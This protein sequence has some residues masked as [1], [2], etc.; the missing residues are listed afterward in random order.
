MRSERAVAAV[1]DD[2]ELDPRRAA[3]VEERLDRS[4]D[5]AAGVEDVVDE[6]DGSS[7]EREVELR[8]AHDGLRMQRRLAAADADVVAVEGDVDGADLGR[9][10]RALLDQPR[11]TLRDRDAARLDPDERDLAKVGICLDDLVRDPRERARERVGVEEEL[12]G[13]RLGMGVHDRATPFRP[14]WTGLKGFVH[15]AHYRACRMSSRPAGRRNQR[16]P[17]GWN[18][19]PAASWMSSASPTVALSPA[20]RIGGGWGPATGRPGLSPV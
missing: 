2:G 11:E 19:Q 14:R 13:F 9:L 20:G 4:A 17:A 3:V 15:A 6:H 8:L 10:A 7:L 12:P 5:R 16:R 1:D 18:A